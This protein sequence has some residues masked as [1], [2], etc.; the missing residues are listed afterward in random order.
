MCP[1]EFS[2]SGRR[3]VIQRHQARSLHYDLRL[4]HDGVFKSWALPK[5]VPIEVGV[6]HLAIQTEDHDLTFGNFQG[7]IPA[8]Q[9]GAGQIEI[10]GGG[11]E[12]EEEWSPHALRF[13]CT[14]HSSWGNTGSCDSRAE[15]TERGL[16]GRLC[17]CLAPHDRCTANYICGVAS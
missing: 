12:D 2:L 13:P 11:E 5:G 3:F 7:E 17:H 9:Y 6:R 10:W 1:K 4:E 8:D 16:F 14:V 15:V